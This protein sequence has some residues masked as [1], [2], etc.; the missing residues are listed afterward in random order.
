MDGIRHNIIFSVVAHS[1]LLAVALLIGGGSEIRKVSLLTISI[2]DGIDDLSLGK[3]ATSADIKQTAPAL[4]K[5]KAALQTVTKSS[6]A[7]EITSQQNPEP[8]ASVKPQSDAD[9]GSLPGV[10]GNSAQ[11]KF[12]EV[13]GGRPSSVG[14]KSHSGGNG[15]AGTAS[16]SRTQKGQAVDAGTDALL[17]QRIRDALQANLVY[18]YIARKRR[19]E[20]TVLM[21]F[22]INGRGL[23]EGVRI[24]K[25]S[26]FSILDEAARE[27]VLKTS[28]F[29]AG[30]TLIEV[31]IRFSLRAD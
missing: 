16:S 5:P 20:G 18:P 15:E 6:A 30:D 7:Q 25:G 4:E 26:S 14:G 28:P 8:L 21:E 29:P 24:V 17:K 1:I 23:P 11:G 10:F 19:M 3:Q 9:S 12:S 31:P 13:G 22:R 2:F 27:T